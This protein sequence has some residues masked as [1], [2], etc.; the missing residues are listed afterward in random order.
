MTIDG[1]GS[2]MTLY[3][4]DHL[5]HGCR[6]ADNVLR[7]GAY[8]SGENITI[9]YN[10]FEHN[11]PPPPDSL[12]HSLYITNAHGV[13]FQHNEVH[14]A[15]DGVKVRRTD[16]GVFRHNVFHGLEAIGLHLGGDSGGGTVNN[17]IESNLFYDNG[18]GIVI[19]SESGTQTVP[20]DGVVIANNIMHTPRPGFASYGAHLVVV[21][22]VPAQN[23]SVTNNLLYD[24]IDDDGIRIANPG[25]NLRCA[26]NIVGKF[27]DGVAYELSSNVSG[28][29][30][31][32]F[33]TRESFEALNLTD[34]ADFDFTVT[35]A[36]SM[37]IDQGLDVS[38][39]VD[40]DYTGNP[41]PV[42]S[43]YDIGPYEYA[44]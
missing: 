34:A 32:E 28:S 19:K 44:P 7:D 20:V 10:E 23:I 29:N 12:M 1:N 37:L 39:V 21:N 27:T 15:T 3:G 4:S 43:G 18:G 35:A 24:M 5:I 9:Q 31:L 16:N 42:G 25:S 26:N 40:L 38:D 11:G 33:A 36:S 8:V 22:D 41:R 14:S 2:G 17:R 6:V 13:V 30:N